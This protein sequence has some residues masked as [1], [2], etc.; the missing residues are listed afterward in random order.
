DWLK[1]VW[2]AWGSGAGTVMRRSLTPRRTSLLAGCDLLCAFP[3]ADLMRG[4]LLEVLVDDLDLDASALQK[5][6]DV[7]DVLLA[8]GLE[9]H[10]DE[11]R[12]GNHRQVLAERRMV[13]GVSRVSPLLLAIVHRHEINSDASDRDERQLQRDEPSGVFF[14]SLVTDKEVHVICR[15]GISVCSD[16]QP[17][18][19]RVRNFRLAE[20]AGSGLGSFEDFW[21]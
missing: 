20:L 18:G 16:R 1:T 11:H 13:H 10:V 8:S 17:P 5:L 2:V 21:G 19:E 6:H 3:P 7:G 15:P 14:K 9:L 12:E 4:V